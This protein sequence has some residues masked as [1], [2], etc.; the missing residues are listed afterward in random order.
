M[1]S[2]YVK[3]VPG[4][5]D[6]QI[7]ASVQ[8]DLANQ[9]ALDVRADG[10]AADTNNL[11]Y[12]FRYLAYSILA[13]LI[14]GVT[15]FMMAFNDTDLSNR[16]QCS[17]MRPLSMNIQIILGNVTFAVVVWAANCAAVFL[18]FGSMPLNAG[19]IFLCLNALAL[20]V[21][22][23]SIGF[24]AGKF[25]RSNPVQS[26]VTNVVSLGLCFISGVFVEQDLLGKTVL[27]ISRFMPGYWY[28]KAVDDIRNAASYTLQNMLPAI[29]GM[30]IQLGFAVTI[31]IVALVLAKQIKLQREI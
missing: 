14:M 25:I 1:A 28:V 22:S 4:M 6:S 2:L 29:Y 20:S 11:S 24:L 31:F 17:P 27:N 8:K 9:A 19:T 3:N 30:L 12:Y 5:A 13:V 21:V 10:N 26:A 16:N 18:M 7:V 23:L 15:S